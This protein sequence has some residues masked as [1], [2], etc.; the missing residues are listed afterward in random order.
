MKIR[1]SRHITE[2]PEP[3]CPEGFICFGEIS[4]EHA[5]FFYTNKDKYKSFDDLDKDFEEW[6]STQDICKECFPEEI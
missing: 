4:V 3:K 5:D 6:L 1:K 2:N